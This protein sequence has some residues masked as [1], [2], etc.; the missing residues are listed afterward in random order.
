VS[1]SQ[2][3][4]SWRAALALGFV[5][6]PPVAFGMSQLARRDRPSSSAS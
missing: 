1:P 3:A 4:G 6:V 5:N 2:I